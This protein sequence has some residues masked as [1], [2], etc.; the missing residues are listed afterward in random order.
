[1]SKPEPGWLFDSNK[2]IHIRLNAQS[3]Y[4]VS[5]ANHSQHRI[6]GQQQASSL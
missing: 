3:A 1:M 4:L 2:E 6:A 5:K